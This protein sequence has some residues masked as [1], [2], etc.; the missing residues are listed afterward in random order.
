MTNEIQQTSNKSAFFSTGKTQS[1]KLWDNPVI[2]TVKQAFLRGYAKL[3]A[4][5]LMTDREE[6]VAACVKKY[7]SSLPEIS[8]LI[9]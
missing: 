4:H 7:V 5:N 9:Q 3:A 8:P 6:C 2:H 1:A